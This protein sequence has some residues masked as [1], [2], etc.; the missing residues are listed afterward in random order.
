MRTLL[1]QPPLPAGGGRSPAVLV[2]ARPEW[3]SSSA[4]LLHGAVRQG[5]VVARVRCLVQ[6]DR[7]RW[8]VTALTAAA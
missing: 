8:T 7:G 5:G 1:A 3:L 2:R 4:V 6:R